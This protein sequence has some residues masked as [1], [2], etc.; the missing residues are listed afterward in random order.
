MIPEKILETALPFQIIFFDIILEGENGIY[1]Y[2]DTM[3][4]LGKAQVG[5]AWGIRLKD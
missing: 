3:S 1:I 2:S 4:H 5:N